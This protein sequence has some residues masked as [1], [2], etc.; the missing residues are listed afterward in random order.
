MKGLKRLLRE[1]GRRRSSELAVALAA[2]PPGELSRAVAELF[3]T[4]ELRLYAKKKASNICHKFHD[5]HKANAWVLEWFIQEARAKRDEGRTHYAIGNLLEKLRHDVAHGVVKVDEFRIANELQAPY[6]R[7][8]L[9]RDPSLCGL[10]DIHVS[11]ADELVFEGR[12]WLSFAEE[13]KADIWP[14]RAQKKPAGSECCSEVRLRRN[15]VE[16]DPNL[17]IRRGRTAS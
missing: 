6:V 16:T 3:A 14:D 12:A 17:S 8:V 11:D 7:A 15:D 5:Y 2:I 9:I 1:Y 4:G 13:R 10:F